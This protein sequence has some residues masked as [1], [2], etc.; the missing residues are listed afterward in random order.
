M[1]VLEEE[2]IAPTSSEPPP[3]QFDSSWL[4]DGRGRAYI[5]HPESNQP[6]YRRGEETPD[7]AII[8][9]NRPDSDGGK[10]RNVKPK[11]KAMPKN[12]APVDL[13]PLEEALAQAFTMPGDIAGAMLGD[14]FLLAHFRAR[15]PY[16]ARCLLNASEQNPWLRKKL[17]ELAAGGSAAM[18]LQ[19]IIMLALATVQYTVPPILYLTGKEVPP[20]VQMAL[21]GGVVPQRPRPAP[22]QQPTAGGANGSAPQA[23]P[24]DAA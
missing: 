10:K 6:V 22:A 15:G 2:I 5:K 3:V 7:E 9:V 11:A 20:V 13:K 18:Q 17:E 24:A 19:A 16:L 8:R 4:I 14:E 1:S 21:L 12:K 23:E